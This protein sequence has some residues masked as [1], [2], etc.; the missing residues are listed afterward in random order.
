M[1]INQKSDIIIAGVSDVSVGYGSP[2]V[3]A[4]MQSLAQ[5]YGG[6]TILFEPDQ[7]ERRVHLDLPS[8]MPAERIATVYHPHHHRAGR[9]EYIL[10]IA[11]RLDEL[12]PKVLVIFCTYSLPVLFKLRFRPSFVVYYSV[13]SIAS[14]GPF[15][16]EVNRQLS[17]LVDLLIFPEENRA[18][19]DTAR[20]QF[21]GIP[22][23]ILYN[24][25]NTASAGHETVSPYARNGRIL[26]AGTIDKRRTFAEYFTHKEMQGVP[27][28]LFGVISGWDHSNN[29]LE[30]LCRPIRYGGYLDAPALQ[31]IRKWYCY[32]LVIWNPSDENQLYA[33]PNKFFESIADGVPPITAPHPQCKMLIERYRCGLVMRDWSFEAF[34]EAL[35][36][37]LKMYGTGA[38]T[39]MVEGCRRAVTQELTWE[40]QFEKVKRFLKEIQ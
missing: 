15:D 19:G 28:D 3:I 9:I 16:L 30:A 20:C 29:F 24:C 11:R 37:G 7:L 10:Q 17:G 1:S 13:E 26:Y 27:L 33:A 25:T 2:Q 12:C 31:R 4:F 23:I 40:R 36:E 8:E 32:S 22:K 34:A 6:E 38:Y 18:M 21:Q 35:H 5:H 14:Y 39:D